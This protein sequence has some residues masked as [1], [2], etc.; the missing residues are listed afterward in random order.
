M[1]MCAAGVRAPGCSPGL[2]GVSVGWLQ[3]SAPGPVA[4]AF[5]L[6]PGWEAFS[7]V[8]LPESAVHVVVLSFVLE[9]L[10]SRAL[11]WSC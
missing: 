9:V 11:S 7:L 6:C 1:P 5:R 3:P 8:S 2:A 10:T 4:A